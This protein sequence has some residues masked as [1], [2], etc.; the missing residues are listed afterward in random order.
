[1]KKDIIIKGVLIALI[2]I[3]FIFFMIGYLKDRVKPS[4][5]P[6]NPSN[7]TS[8]EMTN[9]E[10]PITDEIHEDIDEVKNLGSKIFNVK[11]Y[12]FNVNFIGE[13]YSI[14]GENPHY[15]IST[16]IY[17]DKDM[18]TIS[19]LID[20][21]DASN[22]IK[23]IDDL[24]KLINDLDFI[25]VLKSY[26]NKDYLVL[27]KYTGGEFNYTVRIVSISRGEELCSL[28]F[29]DLENNYDTRL[30][31]YIINNKNYKVN[32]KNIQYIKTKENDSPSNFYLSTLSIKDNKIVISEEKLFEVKQ[33][34][35]YNQ[36][37]VKESIK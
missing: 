37:L 27:E 14:N 8:N 20:E 22:G 11:S 2:A 18:I 32:D 36:F 7:N 28:V 21:L 15:R 29:N 6:I 31:K 4:I 26:D 25:K 12:K 33:D 5:D 13:K 35:D 1:M 10:E 9:E 19:V 17:N 34:S 23:N 3:F 16:E 30:S 24:V